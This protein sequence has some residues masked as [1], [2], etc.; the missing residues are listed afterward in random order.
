MIA[1]IG[2]GFNEMVCEGLLG[3]RL[4]KGG[5]GE[6]IKECHHKKTELERETRMLALC[7]NLVFTGK[8]ATDS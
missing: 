3:R 6:G 8:Q 1:M 2:Q 5:G 4:K 7:K